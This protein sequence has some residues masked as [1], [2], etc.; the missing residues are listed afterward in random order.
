L[1]EK[2][3]HYAR[4]NHNNTKLIGLLYI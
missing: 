1:G 3:S 2:L 4:E